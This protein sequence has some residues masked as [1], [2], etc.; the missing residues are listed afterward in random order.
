[1]KTKNGFDDGEINRIDPDK[2]YRIPTV[3]RILGCHPDTAYRIPASRLRRT[4]V[5]P[6]R[7]LTRVRGRDLLDYLGIA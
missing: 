5:G 2:L 4:K 7:G 1:M 3:A 6:R